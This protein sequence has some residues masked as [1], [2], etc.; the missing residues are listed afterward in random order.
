MRMDGWRSTH[1]NKT[2]IRVD[3]NKEGHII[4]SQ[5]IPHIPPSF[6]CALITQHA[7]FIAKR[8]DIMHLR[9]YPQ[10]HTYKP[11][12]ITLSQAYLRLQ[13]IRG[14]AAHT[15]D[16]FIKRSLLYI[17]FHTNN[18]THI[19]Y[20]SIYISNIRCVYIKQKRR[21]YTLYIKYIYIYILAAN[22]IQNHDT[23]RQ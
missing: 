7:R 16:P 1:T 19:L 14:A 17:V 8:R 15:R 3:G 11:K 22:R 21:I 12:H 4:D 6:Q 18:M 20:I 2:I 23:A 5:T 9:L 13:A 10:T